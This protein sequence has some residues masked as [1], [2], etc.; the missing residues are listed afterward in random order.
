MGGISARYNKPVAFK[1]FEH[2]VDLEIIRFTGSMAGSTPKR[3]RS[4][5]PR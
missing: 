5:C 1:A 2:L 4:T 3:Y